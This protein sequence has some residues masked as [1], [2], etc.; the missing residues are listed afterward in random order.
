MK[1]IR[2]PSPS[3]RRNRA[4][5]TTAP[6]AMTRQPVVGRLL[7]QPCLLPTVSFLKNREDPLYPR[8][9]ASPAIIAAL[10]L[11]QMTLH[12]EVPLDILCCVCDFHRRGRIDFP[13][14]PTEVVGEEQRFVAERCEVPLLILTTASQRRV[15]W[16]PFRETLL[17]RINHEVVLREVWHEE[18]S[19]W[20]R[21][22]GCPHD[23][24]AA[25]A[26]YFQMTLSELR[27]TVSPFGLF[28]GSLP[29]TSTVR[30][31]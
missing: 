23:F 12:V 14:H 11:C 10:V 9:R 3:P 4:R 28:V 30:N 5:H 22:P 25:M 13:P 20:V 16:G 17:F 19:K 15:R 29:I 27:S 8:H 7:V 24:Y 26:K 18:S 31:M 6:K 2:A 1:P 21:L